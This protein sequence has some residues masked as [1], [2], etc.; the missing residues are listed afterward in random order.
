MLAWSGAA[1]AQGKSD[2]TIV[3][4][5][6][7]DLLEPC[8]ATRSNI[9]RVILQNIS[10]TLTEI[11]VRNNSTLKPRLATSWEQVDPTT[12]RFHLRQNVTFS[13]GSTFD[14]EDVKHS[15]ERSMSSKITC[16]TSRYFGDTKITPSVVD[17]H[18][19]D[20]KTDPAEPVLP[21]LMSLLTIVPSETP[22][23]F[24][25]NPIGTGP[26][27]LA[28]WTPGQRIVLTQRDGYWGDKPAV[29]KATYVFRSDS[30]VRAAMVKTGEADIAPAISAEDATDK[31]IDFS[32]PNSETLYIRPDDSMPPLNDKRVRKA[33]NMAIDRQSFIGSLL[34]EG[35]EIA[36]TVVPSTT[37]GVPKDL[38]PFPYDP[39]GAK[40]LLAEAKADGVPV[41]TKLELV[42]RTNLFPNV[43]EVMEATLG[44]L[45]D[46]GFNVD[47]KMH[48]VAEFEGIYSKPFQ[49]GRAPQL[50]AAQHDNARGDPVFSMFWKYASDGRQSTLSDPHVDDLIKQATAATGDKRNQLWSELFT[51]LH[52]DVVA[53]VQLFHMVSF[54]RISP[55]LD[56]KPS[57]AL[58]GQLQL[59]EIKFK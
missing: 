26:Y 48:E 4:G 52:D 27:K 33:L 7:T 57:I 11:D 3:L 36:T 49:K 17:D 32:Y 51:Y 28:E 23:E 30:A 43:T 10:E 12:W 38:K 6:Q 54:A 35:T 22:V 5:E 2:V 25:R 24:T 15:I 9:G 45:K 44:M 55:K 42:G 20:I 1:M 58:N 21:L 29:A 56:Y 37:A 40:K 31:S 41:D 34:P 59:S 13:D 19:I 39:E 16:E 50:V 46:A 8:M 47:L 53:D 18:T 14:A